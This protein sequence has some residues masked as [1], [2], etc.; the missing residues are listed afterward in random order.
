MNL[1]I[2]IDQRSYPPCV[3][4]NNN[5]KYYQSYKTLFILTHIISNTDELWAS[6][7]LNFKKREPWPGDLDLVEGPRDQDCSFAVG[8]CGEDMELDEQ[9]LPNHVIMKCKMLLWDTVYT[10]VS[11]TEAF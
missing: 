4:T 10:V 9:H 2:E 11:G 3:Y 6:L 8:Q 1:C 7:T 5:T